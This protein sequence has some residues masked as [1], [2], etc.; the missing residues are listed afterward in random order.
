MAIQNV[1]GKNAYVIQSEVPQAKT[2]A[3]VGYG[4]LHS[5]LRWKLWELAQESVKAEMGMEQKAYGAQLEYALQQKE[6]LK[7]Q[8]DSLSKQINDLEK[9]TAKDQARVA[10][11]ISDDRRRAE[12]KRRSEELSAAPV[13]TAKGG[14]TTTSGSGTSGIK[15]VV[16]P[17]AGVL[18]ADG[19]VEPAFIQAEGEGEQGTAV[20]GGGEDDFGRPIRAYDTRP[21]GSE[22]DGKTEYDTTTTR[23]KA[24]PKVSGETDAAVDRTEDVVD[25]SDLIDRLK[26]ERDDLEKELASTGVL[27]SA[28]SFDLLERTRDKYQQSY[29]TGGMFGIAPRPGK[30]QPRFDET[31]AVRAAKEIADTAANDALTKYTMERQALDPEVVITPE[32]AQEVKRRGVLQALGTLG[33]R[34]VT[35]Q[36]FL[37]REGTGDQETSGLRERRMPEFLKSKERR[38]AEAKARAPVPYN[39][40]LE[41]SSV[42]ERIASTL[43]RIDRGDPRRKGYGSPSAQT[44]EELDDPFEMEGYT[45]PTV[46]APRSADASIWDD[47]MNETLSSSG[48]PSNIPQGYNAPSTTAPAKE[49]QLEDYIDPAAPRIAPR[50]APRGAPASAPGALQS[51]EPLPRMDLPAYMQGSPREPDAFIPVDRAGPA[52]T[53]IMEDYVQTPGPTE[54]EALKVKLEELKAKKEKTAFDKKVIDDLQKRIGLDKIP[55]K[56]G[57]TS[58]ERR[59][60]Y[61]L[62]L[63]KKATALAAQPKKFDR[64]AKQ[65][66]PPEERKAKVPGYIL[67]VDN[68]YDANDRAGKEPVKATFTELNRVFADDPKL[69]E[70]AQ[71]YLL[72]KD[73]LKNKEQNPEA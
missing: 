60:Q 63:I 44:A 29:G 45:D 69:R 68:L 19:T 1:G 53:L 2:S 36:N 12:E 49:I 47:I 72:A 9:G 61:K 18:K 52:D 37:R 6:L 66:L 3:G 70:A 17:A 64:L 14:T 34:E 46:E 35:A 71:E 30:T 23:T 26:L 28:P 39:E 40:S 57:P 24:I 50:I 10:S 16:N 27:P 73:L 33:G 15:M 32:E 8:R 21:R 41:E 58:L 51:P 56:V 65:A 67:L 22:R 4:S 13:T 62:D 42:E 54:M 59:D 20:A 55:S 25:Y 31:S 48:V 5:Q 43:P 7:D 38:D 11:K